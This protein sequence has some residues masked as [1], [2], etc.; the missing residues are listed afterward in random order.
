MKK[1]I[2]I[3]AGGFSKS[4]VDA[5]DKTQYELMGFLDSYKRG[6]HIEYEILGDSIERLEEPSK[7]NYFIGIGDPQARREWYRKLKKRGLDLINVVDK[8][9]ILST[10]IKL[11]EGIFIG[12]MSIINSD[13]VL[14][15]NVVINTRALIE[16]GNHIKSHS[17]ISTNT[18]LNGDVKVGEATF[19]GSCTVVNGQIKIGNNVTVG[20]GS[21]VIKDI[22]DNVVVAGSPTRLI[23][24]K[25]NE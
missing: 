7:Y 19:I 5:L 4:I 6:S 10:R 13:T 12:K 15:D 14:E 2:I 8:S 9:A 11:G 16:H 21:V 20:S 1:L 22:E 23:R 25:D 24:R 17:N 18:V 3:G